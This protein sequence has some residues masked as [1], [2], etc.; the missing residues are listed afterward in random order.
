MLAVVVSDGEGGGS[1][2]EGPRVGKLPFLA[3]LPPA[4]AI[5][6]GDGVGS[7]RNIAFREN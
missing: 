5:V 2:W 6:D 1:G 4:L 7:L 3:A